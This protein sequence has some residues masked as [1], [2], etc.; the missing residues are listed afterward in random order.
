M[1]LT[2]KCISLKGVKRAQMNTE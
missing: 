2:S 1:H